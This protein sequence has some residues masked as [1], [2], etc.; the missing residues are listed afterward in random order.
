MK[1]KW[2][3]VC[4]L[5][6]LL[7]SISTVSGETAITKQKSN[8]DLI[9]WQKSVEKQTITADQC[10]QHIDPDYWNQ[11]SPEN[12]KAFEKIAVTVPALPIVDEAQIS[13]SSYSETDSFGDIIGYSNTDQSDKK[14]KNSDPIVSAGTLEFPIWLYLTPLTSAVPYG[15]S[16]QTTAQI[17]PGY[18]PGFTLDS[19]LLKYENNNWNIYD[20]GVKTVS[21]NN[22]AQIWK[23]KWYPTSQRWYLTQ[24]IAYGA[25]PAGTIPEA[26]FSWKNSNMVY[27]Q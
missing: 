7:V 1:L 23:V 4:M 9:S 15:I 25:C 6:I 27:Y 22:Y 12:K 16:W 3:S 5:I 13:A 18:S 19:Y 26:F 2:Y 8:S 14:I 17:T 24:G 21:N 11:L 10:L 20:H